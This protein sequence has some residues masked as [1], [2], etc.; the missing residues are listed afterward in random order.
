MCQL[1]WFLDPGDWNKTAAVGLYFIFP[2]ICTLSL[3]WCHVCPGV[4]SPGV[5]SPGVISPGVMCQ[6]WCHVNKR[7]F[8]VVSLKEDP[9]ALP[10]DPDTIEK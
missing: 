9:F 2:G 6:S 3:S 8:P 4:I 1:S 10:L 7:M 5:I